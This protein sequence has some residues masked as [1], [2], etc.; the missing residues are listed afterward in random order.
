MKRRNIILIAFVLIYIIVSI[1]CGFLK[2][3]RKT[4]YLGSYTKVYIDDGIKIN[5]KGETISNKKIKYYFN[6]T[7]KSG[8]LKSVGEVNNPEFHLEVRNE[9]GKIIDFLDDIIA[10]TTNVDIEI[11]KPSTMSLSQED[12]DLITN[13]LS[14]NA[15]WKSTSNS[16]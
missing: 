13:F 6:S 16:C 12:K 11:E 10:Y 5:S 4:V 9:E 3:D 8:Y 14:N 1:V 2:S 7:S 15:S